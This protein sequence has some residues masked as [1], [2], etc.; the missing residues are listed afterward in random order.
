[1]KSEDELILKALDRAAAGEAAG[2]DPKE[3]E[4]L[5]AIALGLRGLEPLAAPPGFTQRVMAALPEERRSL[6]A[7]LKDAFVR[8]HVIRLNL[9]WGSAAA[10]ALLA[11]A[12]TTYGWQ[13]RPAR[14]LAAREPHLVH[15]RFTVKAPK[16]RSVALA[17]D[18]NGWRQDGC[19]LIKAEAEGVWTITVPLRPGRYKYMYIVDGQQWETDP[20]AESYEQDGFGMRNAIVD[21]QAAE[22]AAV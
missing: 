21:V 15:T 3:F 13:P 4:A 16:A 22:Q 2:V 6:W 8:P 11:V 12:L 10:V 17:G 5:K 7:R 19:R 1:M 20:L 9:A 18:F 14:E